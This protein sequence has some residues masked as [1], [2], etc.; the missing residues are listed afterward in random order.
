MM[1]IAEINLFRMVVIAFSVLTAS[2]V[3]ILLG[4]LF[5]NL[6]IRV[7][8]KLVYTREFS[9][10]DAIVGDE[11]YITETIYNPSIIPIPFV[12]IASYID[13][14]LEIEDR[15][16][17]DGMQL[18]VSR[19]HLLPF[20]KTTR[21]HKVVC[22][23][24]GH[25]TM[26]SAGILSKKS[27][28]EYDQ[29]FYFDAELFVFP[30]ELKRRTSSA[31]INLLQGESRSLN[32]YLQDP[33]SAVGVRDMA[34][35]DPFNL[36]NFKATAKSS[37]RGG[38]CIKVNRLDPASDRTYMVYI[39]FKQPEGD[40]GRILY[41]EKMERAIAIASSFIYEASRLGYK[42]GLSANCPLDDGS[43]KISFPVSGGRAHALE[44]LRTLA[45]ARVDYASS[46]TS[47]VEGSMKRDVSLT[48]VF[49]ISATAD[50]G[51]SD[52]VSILGR[53]NSVEVIR[54]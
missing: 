46:F 21:R 54:V 4:A 6:K 30:E 53:R 5:H 24:R 9:K 34:P 38:K 11:L 39:N 28:V 48:E 32:K 22:T 47:I 42:V 33:F 2:V 12:D 40:E 45:S 44:I 13:G 31:A 14:S 25:F 50:E 18:I 35:G 20:A 43:A 23:D 27:K 36:I 51:F 26:K 49:V 17:S 41:K 3:I 15:A 19:F 1:I 52:A 10:T 37:Y 29:T 7:L 8:G 16:R